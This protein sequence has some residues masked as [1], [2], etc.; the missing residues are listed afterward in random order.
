MKD[1]QL[2]NIFNIIIILLVNGMLYKNGNH[3]FSH[4]DL[5]LQKS[6]RYQHHKENYL[7]SLKRGIIPSGLKINKQ[8]AIIPVSDDFN[9]KWNIIL[10]NAEKKLVEV[11]LAESEK[12]IDT[13]EIQIGEEIKQVHP[14]NVAEKRKLIDKNYKEFKKRLER[15]RTRKWRK[16]QENE[17]VGNHNGKKKKEITNHLIS[18]ELLVIRK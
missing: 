4:L 7:E 5:L 11:L 9:N 10:Q 2:I 8:P 3:Q 12:I 15:R 13:L 1:Y 6:L 16:F 14:G 18:K 17:K